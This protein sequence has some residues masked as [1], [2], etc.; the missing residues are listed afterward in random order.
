[1]KPVLRHVAIGFSLAT[2]IGAVPAP[3]WSDPAQQPATFGQATL[4]RFAALPAASFVSASEPSGFLIGTTPINGVTPPFAD[5]P[6]QGFSGAIHNTDGTFDVISDNGYGTHANSADFVLRIHRL[7]ADFD[8]GSIDVVGGINLSDPT[9]QVS[10]PLVRPDR[11]LTGADFDI[12]SIVG[13]ADGSFWLGEEFGPFLLHIDRAGRLLQAPVAL[14]GVFS[15]DN[16]LRGDTPPNLPPSRGFESLV[17]SPDGHTLYPLLEGTLAGD[18]PGSLR[19]YEFDVATSRYTGKRWTYQLDDPAHSVP[20]AIAVDANRFLLLERDGGQGDDAVFKHLYLVDRRHLDP[21]A[22]LHK[23]LV[24]DLLNLANP[25]HIGGFPDPFRFP[26][27]TIEGLVL[28]SD[29]TIGVLNDNNYPFSTGRT[30]N[31]PD[32]NEFII[33][34]LDRN[35]HPDPRALR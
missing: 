23:T 21:D 35:L 27:V 10:F 17:R 4:L 3:A 11:V 28:L 26:F 24:A 33:I 13:L 32:N 15:P 14:P 34:R 18:P 25:Q 5:Q 8:T 1:M 19:L 6:V 7:A 30:P 2:L 22:T 12:E 9:G 31:Q 29:Q 20:D 16:P